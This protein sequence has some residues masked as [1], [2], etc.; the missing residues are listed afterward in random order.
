MLEKSKVEILYCQL[1]EQ[2]LAMRSGERVLPVRQL[3]RKY[4]FSQLTV[5]QALSRLETDGKVYREPGKGFFVRDHQVSSQL[6]LGL[7]VPDWPS[8]TL[9]EL[10]EMLKINGKSAGYQ[11]SRYNY[12]VGSQE[13]NNLPTRDF[14]VIAMIPCVNMMTPEFIYKVGTASIPVI[15]C[16]V[17]LP[18]VRLSCV[19]G[20][21]FVTGAKAASY[22]ASKGHRKLGVMISEPLGS[23]V[24][25]SRVEGFKTVAEAVGA[26]LTVIDAKVQSGEYAQDKTYRALS[27]YLECQSPDF[28]ALYV[29]SDETALAAM[30]ALTEHGIQIPEQVSVMGSDGLRHGAFY[31]PPLTSIAVEAKRVAATI[32]DMAGKLHDN[33][34]MIMQEYL[35]PT[36]IERDSVKGFELS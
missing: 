34:G 11:V 4:G 36:V 32:I 31:H 30:R 27:E 19:T 18:D 29:V 23:S 1:E 24:I 3:M 8:Q 21:P 16:W 25:V 6:R 2:L 20:D 5:M 9:S 28:T 35:S 12:P 15:L 14:D 22:F 33:P 10:E 13:Q 26:E 7:V 17:S